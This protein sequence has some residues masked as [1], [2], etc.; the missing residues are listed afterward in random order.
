M[1]RKRRSKNPVSEAVIYAVGTTVG[2]VIGTVIATWL[3]ESLRA[4]GQLPGSGPF[5]SISPSGGGVTPHTFTVAG[6]A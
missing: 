6:G 5:P 4:N 2:I 3:V 1:R